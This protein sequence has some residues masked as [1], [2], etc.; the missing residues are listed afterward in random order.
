MKIEFIGVGEALDPILGTTSIF[1]DA[2]TKLL[3][4]CGYAVPRNFLDL[5]HSLDEIDA[6]YI[7][8]FHADHTFGLPFFLARCAE[9]NREK[10]LALLGQPGLERYVTKMM[11]LGYPNT[12][13]KLSSC[14]SFI[15]ST[16]SIK[17]KNLTLAFAE[18]AHSLK[19]YAL[20]V[21]ANNAL[22]AFSGDGALTDASRKLYEHCSV[23]VHEGYKFSDSAT[24]H[25]TAKDV[26]NFAQTLPS[27]ETLIFTHIERNTRKN[28]LLRFLSLCESAKFDILVPEPG[29]QV[30]CRP[31]SARI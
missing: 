13:S 16:E 28:E 31:R 8:H 9:E 26:F 29:D 5:G 27:L 1:L 4:D 19:N 24:G 15:E 20:R 12:L 18:T 14:V 17:F 30:I 3:V 10:P 21:S 11:T 25:A 2:E 23:L 7:S 6:I 22:F